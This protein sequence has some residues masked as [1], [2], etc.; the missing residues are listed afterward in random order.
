M[1]TYNWATVLPYSIASA[2]DQ[3]FT[4]FELLVVGDGCSDESG[5]LVAAMND[6]RVT[7]HN[8]PVNTG[9]Q[10]G[11]NNE[12][13]RRASGDVIAYLGHDDV[14]LPGHLAALV[15]AIDDG[16]GLAHTTALAVNA[17]GR[18][19][20]L[21]GKGWVYRL[22][23]HI[24]PTAVAH[25]RSLVEAVGG[26]HPPRDT[27]TLESEAELWQRMA[28]AG[29]PPR[30]VARLTCVK[31]AAGRR[32]GV[33]RARPNH[34]QAYWLDRIRGTSSPERSLMAACNE[35][36]V[37]A[38][39]PADR[40]ARRVVRDADRRLGVRTRLRR[41]G[42]LAGPAPAPITTAEER[43]VTTRRFKGIDD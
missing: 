22:G 1:A 11:P 8:L 39:G 6:R 7:W 10:S 14:W 16:A 24:P 13:I 12:G 38:T 23:S 3:T 26:W 28:L 18:P 19:R 20:Q 29:H 37:F 42:L 33:Y 21:P 40:A 17:S 27:G 25:D 15:G 36:Y 9:H 31:L 43:R 2:L 35:D 4:D 30:W 32:A 34:E 5:E 41:W